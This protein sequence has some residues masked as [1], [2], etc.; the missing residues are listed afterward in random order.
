MVS[1]MVSQPSSMPSRMIWPASSVWKVPRSRCSPVCV[2]LL[3]QVMWNSAY[4]MGSWVT[5]FSFWMVTVGRLWFSKYTVWSW[6]G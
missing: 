1:L 5:E 3:D 2:L 4:W 6:L